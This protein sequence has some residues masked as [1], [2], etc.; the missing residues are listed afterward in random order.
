MIP[1]VFNG[2]K[3]IVGIT[4]GIAAYKTAFLIRDLVS[5]GA[6]VKVAVTPSALN[7]ITP[8]TLSTLSQNDIIVNT[9]PDSNSSYSNTWHID[10]ATW[11]D[12]MIIAPATI[13]TVAKIVNGF[14]DN[15]LTTLVTAL[16]CPLIIA[17]AADMD[18]YQNPI[19][20]KNIKTLSDLG[21][22][23]VEAEE[24]FL[25]SGLT[26]KG[27]LADLSK[28][29]DAAEIVLKGYKKDLTGRKI[30]VTAGPTQED[31][32]PVRFITNRS[33]GKMGYQIAKS[34]F[35]RGAEVTLI[36]G[37]SSEKIYP[38]IKKVNVKSA[39][40]MYKAVQQELE[41]NEILIM[42][43]AVA[44]YTPSEKKSTKIKKEDNLQIIEL[45][46][47]VD[48]LSSINK[49]NKF[50]VGFALETD[51]EIENAKKKLTQKGLDM[52]VLNSLREAGSGF[53]I[54]TNKIT[55]INK[56]LDVT[57]FPL[58]TKFETA[59]QILNQINKNL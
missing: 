29:L 18:M 39:D 12:L 7:F 49:E 22:F 32:D 13:N 24:G 21:Y 51:N 20:Q 52:I 35:L 11:A 57:D 33:S 34:A 30:L 59:S 46:K 4:G 38:E 6:E 58:L 10:V 43:A 19:T 31:I 16:R 5:N 17:P 15:A 44:D 3:I 36:S 9:F 2:R 56:R 1:S 50:V 54:D 40:E 37:P 48:I 14:A 26:G 25:A 55:I 47:T 42:S 45:T 27:R 8:L 41:E 53:E 28:I 23:V